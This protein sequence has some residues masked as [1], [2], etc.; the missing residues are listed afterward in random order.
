M[1]RFKRDAACHD[2]ST[3]LTFKAALMKV[4]RLHD[5]AVA[6]GESH[7][8]LVQLGNL[9]RPPMAAIGVL[10]REVH[11]QDPGL[12]LLEQG[13]ESL[14]GGVTSRVLGVISPFI[15]AR[16][17]GASAEQPFGTDLRG[18]LE[19]ATR[20][21]GPAEAEEDLG[22]HPRGMLQ[23]GLRDAGRRGH[24]CRTCA[25]E[26]RKEL[27]WCV[28]LPLELVLLNFVQVQFDC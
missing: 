8:G 28:W 5:A 12:S 15:L 17:A 25:L 24:A 7:K 22:C 14:K 18:R 21:E 3:Q 20:L 1:W 2:W 27:L 16:A 10:L 6:A 19:V 4:Q 9:H 13:D 23:D 11:L 26:R